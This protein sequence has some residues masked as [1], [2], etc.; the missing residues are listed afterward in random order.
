M[1]KKNK[2]KLSLVISLQANSPEVRS[3][4]L[5]KLVGHLIAFNRQE[6]ISVDNHNNSNGAIRVMRRNAVF[7]KSLSTYLGCVATNITDIHTKNDII[8]IYKK[9]GN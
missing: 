2:K 5:D 3:S 8:K 9:N 1:K 6:V 7:Q 4:D